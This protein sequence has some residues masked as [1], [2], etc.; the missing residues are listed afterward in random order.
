MDN[1][2]DQNLIGLFCLQAYIGLYDAIGY[3]V[4][5]LVQIGS[6]ISTSSIEGNFPLF[7]ISDVV[8]RAQLAHT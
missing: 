6:V 2:I 4:V 5:S 3:G 1:A 8:I 7:A